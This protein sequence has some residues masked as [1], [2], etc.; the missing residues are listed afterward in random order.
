M[1]NKIGYVD[2]PLKYVKGRCSIQYRYDK[3]FPVPSWKPLAEVMS[4][5]CVCLQVV[6]DTLLN[7]LDKIPGDRRTMVGFITFSNS[8]QFYLMGEGTSCL[9]TSST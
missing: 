1:V 5:G 7:Q 8:V 2:S 6:C 4:N 3:R 9:T